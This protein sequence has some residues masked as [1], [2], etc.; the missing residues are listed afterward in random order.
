[1]T[2]ST[3][4]PLLTPEEVARQLRTSPLWVRKR[5]WAHELPV[6]RVAGRPYVSQKDFDDYLRRARQDLLRPW[7]KTRGPFYRVKNASQTNLNHQ[8]K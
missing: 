5:I 4:N 6:H 7:K 3:I 8:S 1:M 2:P